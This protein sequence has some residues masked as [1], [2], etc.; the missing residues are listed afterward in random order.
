MAQDDNASVSLRKLEQGLADHFHMFIFSGGSVRGRFRGRQI[1]HRKV[2][3]T[4]VL[5][6]RALASHLPPPQFVITTVHGDAPEPGGES[7]SRLVVLAFGKNPRKNLLGQV[8]GAMGIAG[9]SSA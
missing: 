4:A 2:I 6:E 5:F 9:H 8:L 3:V 1:N 7:S